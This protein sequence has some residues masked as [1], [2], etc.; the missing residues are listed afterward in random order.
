[1]PF[2]RLGSMSTKDKYGMWEWGGVQ[3]TKMVWLVSFLELK[4]LFLISLEAE[5]EVKSCHCLMK[6]CPDLMKVCYRDKMRPSNGN[7]SLKSHF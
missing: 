1:M 3:W 4:H 7:L 6:A 2:N 5:E